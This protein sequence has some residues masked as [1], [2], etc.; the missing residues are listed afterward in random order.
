M[1]IDFGG[2]HVDEAAFD[3]VAAARKRAIWHAGDL[4]DGILVVVR[5]ELQPEAR[6]LLLQE[7]YGGVGEH[8]G[9]SID[10]SRHCSSPDGAAC[11]AHNRQNRASSCLACQARAAM[12]RPLAIC[13]FRY[14][15]PPTPPQRRLP[16]PDPKDLTQR[17]AEHSMDA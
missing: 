3:V 1:H 9:V 17:F 10:G 11:S 2:V 15:E 4:D 13:G 16:K 7:L 6:D 12:R 8:M 5:R 14:K